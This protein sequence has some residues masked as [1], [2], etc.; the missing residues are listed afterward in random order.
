MDYLP[1]LQNFEITGTPNET[2]TETE[3][4]ELLTKQIAWL[5]EHRMEFLF[6]QMYRLDIDERQ[7]RSVLDPNNMNPAAEGLA[8]LVLQRQKMRLQTKKDIH[9]DKIDPD[10]AW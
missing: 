5:M 2:F 8:K 6:S 3:V 10:L 7:V 4:L 1:L 9:V